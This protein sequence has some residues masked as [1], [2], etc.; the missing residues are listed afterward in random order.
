MQTSFDSLIDPTVLNEGVAM[1]IVAVLAM[2]LYASLR[3]RSMFGI[4][5]LMLM[6]VALIASFLTTFPLLWFWLTVLLEFFILVIAQITYTRAAT[7]AK[8]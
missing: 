4:F 1:I 3:L 6:V 8:S 2:S 5:G 7:R